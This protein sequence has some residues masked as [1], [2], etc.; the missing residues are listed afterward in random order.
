MEIRFI[1]DEHRNFYEK[2]LARCRIQDSYHKALIYL[3]GLTADTQN[4]ISLLFDFDEDQIIEDGLNQGWQTGSSTK[5][6]RLAFNLWNGYTDQTTMGYTPED[7][8][9]CEFAEYFFEAI[10]LRFPEYFRGTPTL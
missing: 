4:H 5:I 1:S 7:L 10:K 9:C 2:I 8:F 3:L 6:C